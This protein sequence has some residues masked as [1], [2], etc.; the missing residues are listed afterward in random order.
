MALHVISM[1]HLKNRVHI[2]FKNIYIFP[3]L[4]LCWLIK[5]A[6]I[7]YKV[8]IPFN[9]CSLAIGKKRNEF[10]KAGDRSKN[11]QHFGNEVISK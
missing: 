6:S 1:N 8:L 10:K 11:C 5:P 4:A 2:I 3:Q 9:V 7:N